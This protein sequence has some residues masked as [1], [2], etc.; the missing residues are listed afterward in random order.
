MRSECSRERYKILKNTRKQIE[1]EEG[2]KEAGVGE[3]EQMQNIS[4]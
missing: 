4:S 1:E 2:E 3:K